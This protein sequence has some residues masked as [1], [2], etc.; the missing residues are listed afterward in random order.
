MPVNCAQAP[1]V[2]FTIILYAQKV[3]ENGATFIRKASK[4]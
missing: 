1:A 2:H 3:D 4:V